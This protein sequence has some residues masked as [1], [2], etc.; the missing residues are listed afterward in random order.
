MSAV[1]TVIVELN[2][3]L[4]LKG[5]SE[6]IQ[7]NQS[8]YTLSFSVRFLFL[9]LHNWSYREWYVFHIGKAK[10]LTQLLSAQ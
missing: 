9:I 8:L 3:I 6:I 2:L 7:S 5:T 4:V 1:V 10:I